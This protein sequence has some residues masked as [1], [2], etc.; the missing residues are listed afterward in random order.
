MDVSR[1]SG[2]NGI[3]SYSNHNSLKLLKSKSAFIRKDKGVNLVKNHTKN[4]CFYLAAGGQGNAKNVL[5]R[6]VACWK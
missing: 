5:N 2:S 6:N 1:V 4:H 3:T